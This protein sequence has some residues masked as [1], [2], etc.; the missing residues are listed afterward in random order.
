MTLDAQLRAPKVVFF[1]HFLGIDSNGHAYRPNSRE[2]LSNIAVFDH[3]VE[4]I[5]AVIEEF[6]HHDNKTA[7]LATA[8]HGMSNKGSH[9]D[10]DPSNTR[11]PFVAWGAGI[12]PPEA[13]SIEQQNDKT[14]GYVI[15]VDMD[16]LG[17]IYLRVKSDTRLP[18]M[19]IVQY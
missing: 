13:N 18:I 12:A 8:D 15:W 6:Y 5:T 9:G 17:F 4:E 3:A 14:N 10:G 2:Y 1:F 16:L 19:N 7:F 11:T